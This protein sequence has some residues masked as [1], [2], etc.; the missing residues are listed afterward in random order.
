MTSTLAFE[1]GEAAPAREKAL[2]KKEARADRE[3]KKAK[4]KAEA[5]D[6]AKRK[7]REERRKKKVDAGSNQKS[8][9]KKKAKGAQGAQGAQA[10]FP[11]QCDTGRPF[12]APD[13]WGHTG[14]TASFDQIAYLAASL[15]PYHSQHGGR[16]ASQS[17]E[18]AKA[19]GGYRS[20]TLCA[21]I[22]YSN[23]CPRHRCRNRRHR[24]PTANSDANSTH[25]QRQVQRKRGGSNQYSV[26]EPAAAASECES[27]RGGGI[28]YRRQ[29]GSCASGIP[30]AGPA[31]NG[32]C[33]P[34]D[35]EPANV[36][37]G[38]VGQFGCGLEWGAISGV[39]SP[40]SLA[41][42]EHG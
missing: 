2:A 3:A 1:H 21:R 7:K 12:G 30:Q 26:S 17:A 39:P 38:S 25:H 5:K 32:D 42:H 13:M 28:T 11:Y 27:A 35:D 41:E 15:Q 23:S 29:A 22:T 14:A 4:D 6:A 34:D 8:V 37:S 18:D 19:N 36:L 9:G 33:E 10:D 31:A 24:H 20:A 16:S 40:R